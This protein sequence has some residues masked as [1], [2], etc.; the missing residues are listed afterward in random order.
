MKIV[1][2][3]STAIPKHIPIPRPNFEHQWV[4]YEHTSPEQTI[5]RAKDADIVIT[6]KVVF[7][8]ETMKQL[9]NLKLIAITA[10]G[11]NNVDL[12][13]AKELG[14]AVKN[15]TGYS[16]VTVPEH[17]LGLIFALK[18]SLMNW[19]KDQLSAKWADSKQFCY[20]D[21]PITDVKGSTLGVVGKGNLGKEIG[22]LA[23]ALGMKVIYAERKGATTVREGYLPF[24]QV[25]QEA[26]IVTLHCPLTPETTNLINAETLKLMKPTA[27]LI[28]TG[29]G[30][31]VDEKAL[32]EALEN[33][34][35][36]AAALDVLVKEP[37]EKDN[38][39]I[40]AATRLPNLIITPHVAWA[41]DGA[42]EILVKKVT[43]NM[44]E[45]VATGK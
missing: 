6:S 23:E 36:A 26:D 21:Y 24:E 2:L 28:N 13:A 30:P 44:E 5:E 16:S 42:V 4:E 41:S 31:L 34:T 45:F 11:T 29:R 12:E 37:P 22:R 9:P 20:F 15:V 7:D 19:Y 1:F 8:R 17:V 35:I 18:H 40:Q 39:L 38:P 32:A 43:Q 25:L 14:I 33:G 10:T 3:D 27:Y